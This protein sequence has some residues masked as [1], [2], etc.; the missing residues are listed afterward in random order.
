M[1]ALNLKN[2][3]VNIPNQPLIALALFIDP[4]ILELLEASYLVFLVNINCEDTLPN[5]FRMIYIQI[6]DY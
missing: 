6:L 1:V 5:C 4:P 2:T 3:Y